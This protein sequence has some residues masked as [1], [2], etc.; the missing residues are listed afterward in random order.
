MQRQYVLL[1]FLIFI[2]VACSQKYHSSQFQKITLERLIHA[3]ECCDTTCALERIE[4]FGYGFTARKLKND[5]KGSP[6]ASYEFE[7]KIKDEK[8]FYLNYQYF[9][10]GM[11]ENQLTA[12]T[13][14]I[15]QY[16][17]LMKQL[18]SLDFRSKSYT[19]EP[20]SRF[21]QFVYASHHFPRMKL[22]VTIQQAMHKGQSKYTFILAK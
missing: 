17:K 22:I 4:K 3:A 10:T 2:A 12:I 15:Q 18:K 21:E 13:H 16:R 20:T 1:L 11:I 5:E 7:R 8:S 14:D 9:H 6:Y 19:F